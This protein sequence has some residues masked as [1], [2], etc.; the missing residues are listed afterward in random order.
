MAWSRTAWRLLAD[1]GVLR[2]NA[3]DVASCFSTEVD[4][5]ISVTLNG[6]EYFREGL[7][8]VANLLKLSRCHFA[9]LTFCLTFLG[10]LGC[11]VCLAIRCA[12]NVG[13]DLPSVTRALASKTSYSKNLTTKL[14]RR[15]RLQSLRTYLSRVQVTFFLGTQRR[16]S[17][18]PVQY[19]A[20]QTHS[21]LKTANNPGN[22]RHD[23]FGCLWRLSTGLLALL[24]SGSI[25][26]E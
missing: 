13:W 6:F 17:S 4:F 23:S 11:R 5:S 18:C 12:C 22:Y 9:R 15:C 7:N 20:R 25:L 26:F 3:D 16:V 24:P 8:D 2:R 10:C 19:H 1:P 21:H 14:S